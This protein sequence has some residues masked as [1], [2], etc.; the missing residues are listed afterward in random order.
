MAAGRKTARRPAEM[1]RCYKCGS[2]VNKP[3]AKL[4]TKC[5]VK[6]KNTPRK[7]NRF[8][9]RCGAFIK[10]SLSTVCDTCSDD[11]KP[12]P[13]DIAKATLLDTTKPCTECGG[14]RE[15]M[16]DP[17]CASCRVYSDK[18]FKERLRAASA[19]E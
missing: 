17:M 1:I 7:M 13:T 14:P 9:I 19:I 8:C 16:N 11:Y 4:C 15:S 6:N 5:W 2:P 18:A 10:S 3:W 12:V